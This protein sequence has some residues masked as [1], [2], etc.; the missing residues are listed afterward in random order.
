LSD[1]VTLTFHAAPG[2][3]VTGLSRLLVT[4]MPGGNGAS[5]PRDGHFSLYMSPI[6]I[7]PEK[8]AMPVSHPAYYATYLAKRIGSY[9]TLGLAEDTWALNEGVTDDG[10][11]L[12][13]TY[14]IDRER[15]SMF[16][17]ALDRL[18]KGSLVCVFDATDRIQHMFWRYIEK[19][20]P[21]ARGREQAE[22]RDAIREL[23]KH[24]DALVGRVM[25]R[26]RDG[27]VLMVISDH[28]FSSFRRGVNLN[29]W[30][31]REGYLTL[32]P[33]ADGKAEW[34]RDVDWTATKAYCLG[35]T[36]MFLNLKGRE[37]HGTVEPGA[38]AAALKAEIIG[39]LNG[40]RDDEKRETGIREVFDTSKLYSGPYLENA[41]DFLIGYNAG[42]RTSWD[43]ATGVVYG[44]V[45]EDNVKAW[46]GDH[47][48]DPRLV[49]GVFF[50]NRK[51]DTEE[52]ALI[53][54][55]PTALRLFGI[56][57]PPYMDGRPLAG[58]A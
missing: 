50:C 9:S 18:Q 53:D 52:P 38:E 19:D 47:C 25:E 42:Y 39:K 24:N 46:S 41:P 51:V 29:S 20:H 11:F 1:W 5:P 48:I 56:E 55:A 8:P 15:E 45:F 28:G 27:D 3:K 49:P 4:E 26:L 6:N 58:I 32:K 40:L 13:Q 10:T 37:Q 14:D 54:I 57:P 43:C 2:I 17:G 23:Y 35:L 30:L 31:L 33:G 16:F 36:G 44:P 22:H 12:K 7:D 34:L 21:A